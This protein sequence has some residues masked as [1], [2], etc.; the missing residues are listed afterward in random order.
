MASL[1]SR[2]VKHFLWKASITRE[3]FLKPFSFLFAETRDLHLHGTSCHFL[4]GHGVLTTLSSHY[5]SSS[6]CCTDTSFP[7]F[8][9]GTGELCWAVWDEIKGK[10]LTWHFIISC[11]HWRAA[12]Q[13]PDE[14]GL[15]CWRELDRETG[16][17]TGTKAGRQC[18]DKLSRSLACAAGKRGSG[19]EMQTLNPCFIACKRH[20]WAKP[21]LPLDT[22]IVLEQSVNETFE[23][24]LRIN[25]AA[26]QA[27]P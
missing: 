27:L 26:F 15:G 13:P 5:Q 9:K 2:C 7:L 11:H 24:N 8:P 25:L 17:D 4:P 12:A 10:P 16:R 22:V 19:Y 6:W 3:H 1:A 14:L 20:P 23:G 21:S 18:R